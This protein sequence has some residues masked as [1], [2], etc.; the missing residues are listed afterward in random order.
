MG[1]LLSHL[2]DLGDAFSLY[3]SI[4][5]REDNKAIIEQVQSY[6]GGIGKVYIRKELLP[7]RNSGYTKPSAYFRVCKQ[8]EL[9]RIIDHF[10]KFPLKSKKREV[11]N[12]WREMAID[13]TQNFINC[14]SEK[15]KS[16]AERMSVLNQKSR[17]FKKHSK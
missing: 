10:D 4:C 15:F 3:F 11:Y 12:I 1:R 6:F 16:F 2:A 17:A 13:K 14:R 9:I 7:T 5:Q 8:K